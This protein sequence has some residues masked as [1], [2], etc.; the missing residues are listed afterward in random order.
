VDRAASTVC[1]TDQLFAH[2]RLN[3]QKRNWSAFV[4]P[5]FSGES[6]KTNCTLTQTARCYTFV[7]QNR[8]TS[9]LKLKTLTSCHQLYN[10]ARSR[11]LLPWKNNK[12]YK[13]VCVGGGVP[14]PVGVCMRAH[15]ALLTQHVTRV[16]HVV[17][18]FVAPLAP[19]HF[20]T[21]SH[22]RYGFRGQCIEHEMCLLFSVQLLCETFLILRR[23]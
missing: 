23:I 8:V 16:R 2:I 21:L 12:C 20:S 6:L 18:S 14:G 1:C 4:I 5:T 9:V 22:K 10:E 17:T 15:V 11:L 19:P 7:T 13:F 3:F